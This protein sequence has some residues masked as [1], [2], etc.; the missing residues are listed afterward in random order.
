MTIHPYL[1]P[2]IMRATMFPTTNGDGAAELQ[3][4]PLYAKAETGT[5]S[6]TLLRGREAMPMLPAEVE[7][8]EENAV[9]G[10]DSIGPWTTQAPTATRKQ[11]ACSTEATKKVVL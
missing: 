3:H 1:V 8:E 7:V 11:R 4:T 10:A 6:R 2:T 5:A 9:V